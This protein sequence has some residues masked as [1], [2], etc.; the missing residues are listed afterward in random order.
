MERLFDDLVGHMRTVIIAG[1]DMVDSC[2]NRLAQNS[3]CSIAIARRSLHLRTCKLHR[4][5]AHAIQTDG[6]SGKREATAESS[7]CRHFVSPLV[8]IPDL[9]R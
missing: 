1:I 9:A 6:S 7:V 3:D 4:A 2:R 8:C 5:I